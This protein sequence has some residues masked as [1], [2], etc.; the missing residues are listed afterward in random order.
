A[1]APW[2]MRC[3]RPRSD[4]NDCGGRGEAAQGASVVSSDDIRDQGRA[5]EPFARTAN[6]SGA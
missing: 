4:G 3:R 2:E 6:G 1:A 5:P